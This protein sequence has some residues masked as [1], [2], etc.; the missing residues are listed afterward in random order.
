MVKKHLKKRSISLVVR[1]I[2]I[3]M[4][5]RFHLT[6]VSMAKIK[7]LKG[8]NTGKPQRLEQGLFLS[9]FPG[10]LVWPQWEK[11]HIVPQPQCWRGGGL[12]PR[13]GREG[14]LGGEERLI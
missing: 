13:E 14:V 9:L 2:Q 7:K 1:G 4:T 6:P 12:T 8:Q 5:L 3:K 11:M 10:C